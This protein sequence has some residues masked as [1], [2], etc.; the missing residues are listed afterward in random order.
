MNAAIRKIKEDLIACGK[1]IAAKGLVVGPG[2][3]ISARCG[4]WMVISAS[5]VSFE[6]A[7]Q[8]D[9][10]AVD[11]ATGNPVAGAKRP[12]SE[13]LMHLACYRRRPDIHA[14][15]HTHPTAAVAAASSGVALE[16]MFP[17]FV[18]FLDK[19]HTLEYIIPTTKE[20]ADA[21]AAVIEEYNAL[22]L[23]NHGALTLGANL[24]E[25]AL[26]TELLE[27][28]ARILIAAKALGRPRILSQEEVAAIKDL[29]SEKYRQNL[30]KTR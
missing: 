18:A 10:V 2:G 27:E 17:D 1:K 6:E 29:N 22:L 11:I 4:D 25:A 14:V 3:N 24:K 20:L 26:R 28:A 5:G 7:A 30:L 16:P 21:V 9:Y 13:Q 15:V 23:C 8:D 12:S 19:V